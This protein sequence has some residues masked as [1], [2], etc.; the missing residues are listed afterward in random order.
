MASNNNSDR[1]EE[2][3]KQELDNLVSKLIDKWKTTSLDEDSDDDFDPVRDR[4]KP[5]YKGQQRIILPEVRN[6][7]ILK[8]Q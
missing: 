2:Q 4:S 3:N 6:K 7:E 1:V 5:E 8:V